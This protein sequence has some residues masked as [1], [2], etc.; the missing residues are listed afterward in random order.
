MCS[1]VS[2]QFFS[3]PFLLNLLISAA[4]MAVKRK[5]NGAIGMASA[6]T[7]CKTLFFFGCLAHS[8]LL[9]AARR[10]RFET[11]NM[12]QSIRKQL[13]SSTRSVPKNEVQRDSSMYA[14]R[15]L[16]VIPRSVNLL[17]N[18]WECDAHREFTFHSFLPVWLRLPGLRNDAFNFRCFANIPIWHSPPSSSS[19]IFSFLFSSSP[20]HREVLLL[21]ACGELHHFFFHGTK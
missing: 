14:V 3:S 21:C 2:R 5:I 12:L 1:L 18:R 6:K 15:A 20:R 9:V 8:S 19:L 4:F 13:C 17:A 10:E 11:A 7:I 16:N